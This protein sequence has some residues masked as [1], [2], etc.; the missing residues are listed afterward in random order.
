MA[1]R[2]L[3]VDDEVSVANFIGEVLRD[4]GFPTVVFSE[5]PGAQGV[6]YSLDSEALD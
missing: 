1:A 3:V 4:K 5:S 2:I 6:T